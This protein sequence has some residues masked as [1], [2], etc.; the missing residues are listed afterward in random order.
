MLQPIRM[1][2]DAGLA[3]H[4]MWVARL[5]L[6]SCVLHAVPATAQRPGFCVNANNNR[7][8]C[9]NLTLPGAWC[10]PS[11][12]TLSCLPFVR[13][14]DDLGLDDSQCGLKAQCRWNSTSTRCEARLH[15]NETWWHT[16][17]PFLDP[18]TCTS[19]QEGLCQWWPDA[20]M[21][22]PRFSLY[23]NTSTDAHTCNAAVGCEWTSSATC[24]AAGAG[25]ALCFDAPSSAC[26]APSLRDECYPDP[27]HPSGCTAKVFNSSQPDLAGLR[28]FC[29]RDY[30]TH[31]SVYCLNT[32]TTNCGLTCGLYRGDNRSYCTPP[33]HPST[34]G[35]E[36]H[37][38]Y[39]VLLPV[40][41]PID[42]DN[43][44][45][46]MQPVP[47]SRLR[48]SATDDAVSISMT[49]LVAVATFAVPLGSLLCLNPKLAINGA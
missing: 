7:S 49:L 6:L 38:S 20:A 32:S 25:G 11:A 28:E 43:P 47:F 33:T 19:F 23:C 30:H 1:R 42:I 9:F 48:Q 45:A 22:T 12:I 16:C 3:R 44:P 46:D 15:H 37:P 35:C 41:P 5:L 40:D 21:C 24:A 29:R 14:C 13:N 36:I 2:R 18:L 31:P 8:D 10:L 17:E 34:Y 27:L 26:D 4:V 39:Q